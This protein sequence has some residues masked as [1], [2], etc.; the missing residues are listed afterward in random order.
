MTMEFS[1]ITYGLLPNPPIPDQLDG[2]EPRDCNTGDIVSIIITIFHLR[3]DSNMNTI[4]PYRWVLVSLTSRAT[5]RD[6]R[7]YYS[8]KLPI[9]DA[10][11]STKRPQS[12]KDGTL[13]I[14]KWNNGYNWI[15]S[16]SVITFYFLSRLVN[17]STPHCQIHERLGKKRKE[18][19]N[20]YLKKPIIS[21]LSYSTN[22][23]F[24]CT[25]VKWNRSLSIPLVIW[26]YIDS[27]YQ[28]KH[29]STGNPKH[30]KISNQKK[31]PQTF[32][33]HSNAQ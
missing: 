12:S 4:I 29:F 8:L 24:E 30:W 22:V 6:Y 19:R 5:A 15:S 11:R 18:K 16:N 20:N 32:V 1:L 27:V 9:Y 7:H 25:K 10:F 2:L 23:A 14:Q 26:V 33:K 21:I 28:S 31:H 3:G 13:L 17:K